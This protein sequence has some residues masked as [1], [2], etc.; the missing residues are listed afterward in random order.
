[1]K[2]MK[3]KLGP[4][5]Q[6]WFLGMIKLNIKK[7]ES[8]WIY[9]DKVPS[10]W[11]KVIDKAAELEHIVILD[12]NE[13]YVQSVSEALE[14][15]FS[16]GTFPVSVEDVSTLDEKLVPQV[17]SATIVEVEEEDEV[18]ISDIEREEA[19]RILKK[20]ANTIK[21]I[22]KKMDP[23]DNYTLIM[24]MFEVESMGKNRA[25]LIKTINGQLDQ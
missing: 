22:L 24:A 2:K 8:P 7:N 15:E 12:E 13:K 3:L 23:V 14:S 18:I 11:V 16:V 5:N 10:D 17:V 20:N 19:T 6:F 25:G 9:I 4:D 21:A 1:M